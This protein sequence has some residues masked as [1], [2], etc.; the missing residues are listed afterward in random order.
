MYQNWDTWFSANIWATNYKQRL[1]HSPPETWFVRLQQD[2]CTQIL[3]Q[4]SLSVYVE[5]EQFICLYCIKK[6]QFNY[7]EKGHSHLMP[8]V[9]NSYASNLHRR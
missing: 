3:W 1:N 5:N 7:M 6:G 2:G 9:F 8:S 4:F